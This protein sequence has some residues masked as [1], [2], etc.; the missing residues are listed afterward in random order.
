MELISNIAVLFFLLSIFFS[1][2]FIVK[3]ENK[4]RDIS[5]I[6]LIVSLISI[7]LF[8][9]KE[10]KDSNRNNKPETSAKDTS[11]SIKNNDEANV[12]SSNSETNAS[13][14]SIEDFRAF[15]ETNPNFE[16][17]T[18]KYYALPID[19]S[20]SKIWDEVLFKRDVTWTGTVIDPMENK[21]AVIQTNKFNGQDWNAIENTDKP[22]VFFAKNTKGSAFKK[23]DIVTFRGTIQSRGSNIDS[24]LNNWDMNVISVKK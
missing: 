8:S 17:F 11:A 10:T 21:V 4:K 3:K 9:P 15:M 23:G 1:I 12:S 24:T 14:T 13:K 16:S 2:F 20:Q 19:G 22:Y 18:E 5:I 6:V 7:V